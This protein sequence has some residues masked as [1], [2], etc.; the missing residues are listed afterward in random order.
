MRIRRSLH[1]A[2][3]FSEETVKRAIGTVSDAVSIDL[4]DGVPPARKAEARTLTA[5]M[6]QTLDFR[7]KERIVRVNAIGSEDFYKDFEQVISVAPPDTIRVPKCE[8]VK[9]MLMIDGLL[10]QIEKAKGLP[11]NSIEIIAMIESPIG[12][13]NA[14]D[15][16]SCCERVTALNVG[17]EDLTR[18]MGVVRRYANNEL[19][20]I[21]ARQKMVLDAK[22]AG[23]Q[24]IDSCLLVA[25][26]ETNFK[27][28]AD[29]RQMGF[30]GRSVHDNT[31][32]ENAN[33]A[34][35]PSEADVAFAK[36][37]V[38]AY[39]EGKMR[40]DGNIY[41]GEKSICYAAYEKALDVLAYHE[42]L[43]KKK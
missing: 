31:E 23:V 5:R 22:A 15:I 30:D 27:Q 12:I 6:L 28:S 7:G 14:F 36:G 32:A 3:G 38:A 34:F 9:D 39:R 10:K 18:E 29:A 33:R 43:E 4:E 40:E 25:D 21:Y 16:A 8:Y 20:L 17:M 42:L 1:W 35:A 19:D 2:K 11:E 13:R 24:A 41:F 37:A 26:P